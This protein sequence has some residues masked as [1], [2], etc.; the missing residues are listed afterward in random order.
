MKR[1]ANAG[2]F[3]ELY[4]GTSLSE[5]WSFGPEEPRVLAGPDEKAPLPLYGFGLPDEPVLLAE[6]TE[7]GYRVF[8]PPG[9]TLQ[10]STHRDAFHD[11][12]ESQ[13]VQHEGRAS[14]ELPEGTTLRL[15][16]GELHLLLQ[17]SVAKDRVGQFRLQDLGWL[18][19]VIALFLSAPLGFLIAG[20]TP[21]K[22]MES[23]ARALQA[24]K[25]KEE[26]RRK[27]MGLDTP[28]RPMNEDEKKQQQK[29]DGGTQLT[30]PAS[31]SVH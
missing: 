5:A 8:I 19:M 24:A 28:L 6:R 27:A 10:R 23:N 15:T 7:R 12:P 17:H 21:Q 11:V 31:F 16:A 2:L 9:V 4:W 29:T 26:A 30:V 22:M 18:A 20:P 13:L 25:E 3:C 14:V 1:Q